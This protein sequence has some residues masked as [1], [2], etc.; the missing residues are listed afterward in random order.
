MKEKPFLNSSV[1]RKPFLFKALD[2]Q[3]QLQFLVSEVTFAEDKLTFKNWENSNFNIIQYLKLIK[4]DKRL[5][6]VEAV[7]KMVSKRTL[8]KNYV[9][10]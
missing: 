7:F 2:A 1:I 3:N 4:P 9:W 5:E 6:M 8:Y 10:N